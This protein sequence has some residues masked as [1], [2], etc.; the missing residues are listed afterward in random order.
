MTD[1]MVRFNVQLR[2]VTEPIDTAMGR[3]LFAVLSG[4]A[5]QEL[6][7]IVDR[8]ANGR[9]KACEDGFA[10][11]AVPY[12]YEPDGDGGL[13]AVPHEALI[14]RRLFRTCAR[15]A[16]GAP[17]PPESWPVSVATRQPHPSANPLHLERRGALCGPH[18]QAASPAAHAGGP[19]CPGAM[20]VGQDPGPPLGTLPK[21]PLR[22][23][24][25]KT[26]EIPHLL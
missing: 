11:G 24:L 13:R 2:S 4:R 5:E 25:P 14:I 15:P 7:N 3:A 9:A 17:T 1:L 8:T 26:Q 6:K 21:T 12:G 23:V 16:A 18:A 20:R 19:W 10:G 22:F